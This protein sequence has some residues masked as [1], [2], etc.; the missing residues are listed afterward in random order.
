M[1][2]LP[3]PLPCGYKLHE[4]YVIEAELAAPRLG[5]VYKASDVVLQSVVAL[6]VLAPDRRNQEGVR[7]FRG[8]FWK[9]RE[10]HRDQVH[11]YGE[12]LGVPYVVLAYREGVGAA[13]DVAELGN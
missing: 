9:A 13:L 3:E 10:R 1:S 6:L 2:G 11:D 12:W 4:R 7:R 8:W 5:R